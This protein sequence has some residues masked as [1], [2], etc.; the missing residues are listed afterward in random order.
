MVVE[1]PISLLKEMVLQLL[2]ALQGYKQAKEE[3]GKVFSKIRLR[4]LQF[5]QR[6]V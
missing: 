5:L 4:G 3:S 1:I 2:E 6:K